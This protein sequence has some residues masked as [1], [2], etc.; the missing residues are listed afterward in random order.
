[1]ANI[2]PFEGLH[3]DHLP[4]LTPEEREFVTIYINPRNRPIPRDKTPAV[5]AIRAKLGLL[6]PYDP[7]A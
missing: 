4:L 3:Q 7:D 1:M 5:N 6:P 2:A